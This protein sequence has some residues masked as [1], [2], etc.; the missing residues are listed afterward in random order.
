MNK[1]IKNPIKWERLEAL[2]A[3]PAPEI[4][5]HKLNFSNKK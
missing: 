1:V 2:K 3:Q 5:R 4:L